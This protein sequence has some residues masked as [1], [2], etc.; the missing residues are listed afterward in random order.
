MVARLRT[1]ARWPTRAARCRGIGKQLAQEYPDVNA[2]VEP[3]VVPYRD[4]VVEPEVQSA[5]LI[6]MAA[7][8]FVLLIACVNIANLVLARGAGR[9][10][11]MALRSALGA[12]RWR[13]V[14]QLLSESLLIAALG[15]AGGLLVGRLGLVAA[16]AALPLAAPAWL[17]FDIDLTVVA[18][19][20]GLLL[21]TAVAFGLVPALRA[22]R[23]DLRSSLGESGGRVGSGRAGGLAT[24]PAWWSR[25]PSPWCCSCA[26][27]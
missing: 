25:S 5:V 23:L 2:K 10:R 26:R 8:A 13:L 12:S 4:E 24:G 9:G 14:W 7:V 1:D 6:A 17:R 3:L 15:A 11:E 22:S 27:R 21:A 19:V 18:F 20:L 16:N